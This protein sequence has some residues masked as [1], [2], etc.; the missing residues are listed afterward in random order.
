VQLLKRGAAKGTTPL[1]GVNTSTMQL[2]LRLLLQRRR[3]E[4]RPAALLPALAWKDLEMVSLP[5]VQR[6]VLFSTAWLLQ[7]FA[8]AA[9]TVVELVW[10]ALLAA[11]GPAAAMHSCKAAA[12]A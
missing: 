4:H 5:S 11:N 8:K 6:E 12:K 10:L 7:S 3:E 2:L 1:G 9:A